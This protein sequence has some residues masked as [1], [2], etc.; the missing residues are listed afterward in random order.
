MKMGETILL[1]AQMM[2]AGKQRFLVS[3]T[4]SHD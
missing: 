4:I 3:C 1:I 2:P